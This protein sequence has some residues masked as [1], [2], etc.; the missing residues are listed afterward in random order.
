MI[1]KIAGCGGGLWPPVRRQSRR[2]AGPA[3]FP[4]GAQAG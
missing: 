2:A 1:V 3:I 4:G